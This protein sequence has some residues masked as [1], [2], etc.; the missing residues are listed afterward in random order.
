MTQ[1]TQQHNTTKN[2]TITDRF[3]FR[4]IHA[5]EADRAVA[6]EQDL[7]STARSMFR[8]EHEDKDC[9]CTGAVFGSN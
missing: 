1:Q 2:I 7:F 5:E 4:D 3:G 8:K 6:I 9:K